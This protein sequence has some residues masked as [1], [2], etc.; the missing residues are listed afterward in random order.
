MQRVHG[1][2]ELAVDV[3]RVGGVELVLQFCLTCNQR[4]H[5][6]GII[7]HIGVAKCLVDLVKLGKEVHYR[8]HT[9]AYNLNYSLVGVKLG[10]LFEIADR[11]T[12]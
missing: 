6:V 10:F 3:P 1:A 7:K 4:I 11:I 2:L 5:L 8:L 12:G 9:F